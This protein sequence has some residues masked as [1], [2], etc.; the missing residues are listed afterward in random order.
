MTCAPSLRY[1][2]LM[3]L[4]ESYVEDLAT[5]GEGDLVLLHVPL[6]GETRRT[7]QVLAAVKG[8]VAKDFG[9]KFLE[10]LI[11]LCHERP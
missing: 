9:M 6:E 10:F 8:E 2:L 5:L 4:L 11:D 1:D 3:R 7:V